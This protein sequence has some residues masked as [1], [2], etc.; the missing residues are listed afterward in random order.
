MSDLGSRIYVL[1]DWID[2]YLPHLWQGNV[3]GI[4]QFWLASVQLSELDQRIKFG[5]PSI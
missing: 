3:G 5:K 1:Q 4:T 2:G